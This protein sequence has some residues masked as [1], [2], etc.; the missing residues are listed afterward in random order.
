MTDAVAIARI[1][2]TGNLLHERQ[3][4]IRSVSWEKRLKCLS[5]YFAAGGVDRL[6]A[7]MPRSGS[8]WSELGLSLAIDLANGGTGE[9][10]LA[11]DLYM[12]TG[13]FKFKR[14][15]WRGAYG[16]WDAEFTKAFGS[17]SIG[18]HLYWHSRLPYHRIRSGRL[19]KMKIVVLM[20]SIVVSIAAQFLKQGRDKGKWDVVLKDAD[21]VDWESLVAQSIEFC[22]SWGEVMRWHPNIRL[23]KYEDLVNNPIAGHREI[24]DFWGFDVPEECIA[25][26]FRRVTPEEMKNRMTPDRGR[27]VHRVPTDVENSEVVLPENLKHKIIDRL[28]GELIHDFGYQYNHD[29]EFDCSSI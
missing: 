28:Q 7:M 27:A 8:H 12:P 5:F 18:K 9:Y 10:T 11:G 22:N 6:H 15:D 25:E 4:N 29:T 13:G 16:S 1:L 3:N 20:R 21:A 23:Y 2:L 14:L 24:L 17:G 19:K 26:A